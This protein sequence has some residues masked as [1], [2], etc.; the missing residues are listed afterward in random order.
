MLLV[1]CHSPE[2]RTHA[3]PV[4]AP[5][6]LPPTLASTESYPAQA[7]DPRNVDTSK[8]DSQLVLG[9]LARHD[10][11][12]QDGDHV[13][14]PQAQAVLAGVTALES[15]CVMLPGSH[16]FHGEGYTFQD[17]FGPSTIKIVTDRGTIDGTHFG[18]NC[19]WEG[20]YSEGC[21]DLSI[22]PDQIF[23]AHE[24]LLLFSGQYLDSVSPQ[25]AAGLVAHEFAHNLTW[26]HGHN[27]SNVDGYS[28]VRYV[29]DDFAIRF[30]DY[31]GVQEGRDQYKDEEARGTHPLW[32]AELTADAIASWALSDIRGPYASIIAGY[33]HDMMA[34]EI[35]SG[36]G[37]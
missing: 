1:G 8:D 25:Q 12:I 29:G 33:I 3:T 31:L 22:Y 14:L 30:M 4:P 36:E 21:R 7:S 18:L 17:I 11:V 15:K 35:A 23:P 24:W 37:C 2:A 9:Q 6:T 34:C 32:R 19:G 13:T 10:V 20:R 5:A 27:P 28:Y 16:Q 26:G